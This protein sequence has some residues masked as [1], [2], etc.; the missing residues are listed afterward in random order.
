MSNEDLHNLLERC[1]S[2][3]GEELVR[4]QLSGLLNGPSAE[5]ETL[6]IIAN[7]GV[8]AI[9]SQYQRGEV[10]AASHGNWNVSSQSDL[11]AEFK[12][13]LVGLGRKLKQSPWKRI[14]LIPTGHPAL[15]IQ[16]KL[17]VYRVTRIN[18]IDLFYSK[19]KPTGEG[20]LN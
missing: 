12:R 1:V 5:N 19:K 14:Y 4:E 17:L 16:I 13:I 11:E 3:R 9:P 7:S 6:T 2:V 8:H 18:T 20:R 15:A 10:Y